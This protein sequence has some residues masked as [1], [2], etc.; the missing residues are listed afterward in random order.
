MLPQKPQKPYPN[1]PLFAHNNGQLGKKIDGKPR[2]FGVWADW[3]AALRKYHEEIDGPS[4]SLKVCIDR[5]IK[6]C[7]LRQTSEGIP[8]S[9]VDPN[10]WTVKG[11]V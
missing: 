5:Y 6:W 10:V 1:F 7:E 9:E 4:N 3:K 8:L 11:V 2:Y